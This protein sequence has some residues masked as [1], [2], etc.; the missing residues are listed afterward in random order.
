MCKSVSIPPESVAQLFEN[1]AFPFWIVDDRI[2]TTYFNKQ[3]E[4]MHPSTRLP[5]GL[6]MLFSPEDCDEIIRLIAI[7]GSFNSVPSVMASF[8]AT[9]LSFSPF[10]GEDGRYAGAYVV[11][12]PVS[13]D[14]DNEM[15]LRN[16]LL[17]A[18]SLVVVNE[19]KK[20]VSEIFYSLSNCESKLKDAKITLVD[21][22]LNYIN[23]SCYRIM[24]NTSNVSERIQYA[25]N[26]RSALQCVD[27][28][29]NCAELFEACSTVLRSRQSSFTY[30][31]P[32][33]SVYVN[34]DFDKITIALLH[35]ISNAFLHCHGG[36]QVTVTG[37]DTADGVL[38]SISDNGSGIP[39][40]VQDRIFQPF[41]WGYESTQG[42]TMG[43]GLNIVRNT[44]SQAGGKLAMNSSEAGT[45]MVLSLPTTEAPSAM[46]ELC[47]TSASYMQDRF[48]PLYI[49]LCDVLAPPE[50]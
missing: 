19:F 22:Q 49:I 42:S 20:C 28:W 33:T 11:L 9:A 45:T 24:R 44:I 35:L 34:C 7:G 29:D 36:V 23:R 1:S 17:S 31:L 32:E 46:P 41:S 10:K 50:L 12:T 48:S 27:F 2:S 47:S 16:S 39:A 26:I 3:T 8:P 14:P 18:S 21:D 6:R 15:N 40:T 4:F 38:I 25:S 37:K 43:L 30:E 5:D 13:E